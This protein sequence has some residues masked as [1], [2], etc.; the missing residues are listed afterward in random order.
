MG[1]AKK[2]Y[3]SKGAAETF[4]GWMK[5]QFARKGKLHLDGRATL[6][7]YLCKHCG[8]WHLGRDRWRRF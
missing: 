1:C 4:L 5:L 8:Y 3:S 2:K 6:R 7:S